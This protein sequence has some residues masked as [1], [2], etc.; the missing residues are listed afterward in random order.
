[1]PRTE[2]SDPEAEKKYQ[3]L[4]KNSSRVSYEGFESTMQV[5]DYAMPR[6]GKTSDYMTD[7]DKAARR[8]K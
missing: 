3:D 7:A 6:A 1:M 5:G 4:S 2:Y 8:K